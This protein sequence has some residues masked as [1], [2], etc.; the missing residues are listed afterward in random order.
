MGKNKNKKNKC[1]SDPASDYAQSG[2]L[3]DAQQGSL[4][5]PEDPSRS[6]IGDDGDPP[7]DYQEAVHGDQARV[8]RKSRSGDKDFWNEQDGSESCANNQ[9]ATVEAV[10]DEEDARD[11]GVAH[12]SRPKRSSV[13]FVHAVIP[14]SPPAQLAGNSSPYPSLEAPPNHRRCEDNAR[15]GAERDVE[16]LAAW[17]TSGCAYGRTLRYAAACLLPSYVHT[18][19]PPR[20]EPAACA[21]S[22]PFTDYAGTRGV[23]GADSAAR[24]AATHAC[25]DRGMETRC[26]VYWM[27]R[28]G[29][30]GR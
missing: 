18:Y 25:E 22:C 28:A 20:P 2:E 21:V 19:K 5:P 6:L 8:A 11:S 3:N 15:L 16:D 14:P 30:K 9:R 13:E 1:K 24:M 10:S 27:E 12:R 7:S 29:Y 26:I 4:Q 17:A 23:A